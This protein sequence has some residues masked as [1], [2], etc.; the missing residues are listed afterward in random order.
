[1]TN[2]NQVSIDN[3]AGV[4]EI[5][6]EIA[7]VCSGGQI[8]KIHVF[9]DP[10]GNTSPSANPYSYRNLSYDLAVGEY[11]SPMP[12]GVSRIE[13]TEG[14]YFA[15]SH[16]GEGA[17]FGPGTHRLPREGAD[18]IALDPNSLDNQIVR[19]MRVK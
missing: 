17:L 11:F 14:V 15:Q 18:P 19:I 13:I 10:D 8:G 9:D 12:L 4:K 7:S 6:D 1:M 2:I 5:T 3:I 16:V